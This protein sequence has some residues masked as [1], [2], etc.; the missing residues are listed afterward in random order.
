MPTVALDQIFL[1]RLHMTRTT[2]FQGTTL[3]LNGKELLLNGQL[4]KFTLTGNTMSDV[5][6]DVLKDKVGIILSV[7]SLDT[8][9]CAIET[10]RFNEEV[11]K[12]QN[13]VV[14][15]VSR[16]L[17]FAQ[18]RW[19]AAEGIA[20]VIT[21]SDYKYRSFG[22]AFGVEIKEWALLSRAVFVTGQDGVLRYVE[23]VQ[24]IPN[25]PNYT[26]VLKIAKELTHG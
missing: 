26:E 14:L 21:A 1:K 2:G 5:T 23:Y 9:V 24:E 20:N 4:P 17:P 7:P 6:N 22:E 16:D 19:C 8:P 11:A 25:E 18:K 3:T 12:L 13:V 15:A 10:K